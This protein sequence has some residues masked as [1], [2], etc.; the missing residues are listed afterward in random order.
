MATHSFTSRPQHTISWNLSF[1]C[2]KR[3]LN[4]KHLSHKKHLKSLIINLMHN[5]RWNNERALSNQRYELVN[6]I[7]FYQLNTNSF[8]LRMKI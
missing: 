2:K 4:H 1:C 8:H 3:N 5:M 7:A 6:T